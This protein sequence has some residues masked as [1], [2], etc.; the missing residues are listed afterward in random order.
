MKD[1]FN[2]LRVNEMGLEPCSPAWQLSQFN[3]MKV[4]YTYIY[5][6]ALLPK[7]ADWGPQID[8]VGYIFHNAADYVQS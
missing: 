4:P 5:S 7:P 1:I 3:R 6:P 2:N 8:V